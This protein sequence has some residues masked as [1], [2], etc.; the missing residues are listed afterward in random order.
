MFAQPPRRPPRT[1]R[2]QTNSFSFDSSERASAAYEQERVASGSTDEST[3][4]LSNETSLR[5]E[6]RESSLQ[7]SRVVSA[8]SKPYSVEDGTSVE[9]VEDVRRDFIFSS[10]QLALPPPFSAVSRGSSRAG[11]LPSHAIVDDT[12][13]PAT[14][15]LRSPSGTPFGASV[16]EGDGSPGSNLAVEDASGGERESSPPVGNS[17]SL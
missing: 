5:D 14:S 11:S 15:P 17:S 3:H 6:L 1:F 2:H 4:G 7:S 16:A 9:Y 13:Y 10:P 12:A 8:V